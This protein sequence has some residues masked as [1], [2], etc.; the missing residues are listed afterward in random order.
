VGELI[1][2]DRLNVRD[3]SVVFEAVKA[4]LAAQQPAASQETAGVLLAHVRFA[5]LTK[6]QQVALDDEPLVQQH[7][8]T[9]ATAYREKMHGEDTPRTRRR[10]GTTL[11]YSDLSAGMQ[12]RVHPDRD[13]VKQ[14]CLTA[15]P[16]ADDSIGWRSDVK[17][18]VCGGTY[19]IERLN[20]VYR[21]AALETR[22]RWGIFLY[23]YTVLLPA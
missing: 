1:S 21:S 18:N 23:P 2:S 3:E 20:D 8:K 11:R 4:W 17:G 9:V 6:E 16:G 12:V 15:V 5:Q 13:F 14:Q 22:D 10:T 19:T 7:F